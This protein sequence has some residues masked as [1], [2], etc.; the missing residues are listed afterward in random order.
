MFL[1]VCL[2]TDYRSIDNGPAV[3]PPRAVPLSISLMIFSLKA[4][5]K[6]IYNICLID[7]SLSMYVYIYIYIYIYIYLYIHIEMNIETAAQRSPP[8]CSRKVKG[9]KCILG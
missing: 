9:C 7:I 4:C 8:A 5:A 3:P 2:S 6:N 1:C